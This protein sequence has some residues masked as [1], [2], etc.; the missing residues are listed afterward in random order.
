M[1]GISDRL[2]SGTGINCRDDKNPAHRCYRIN[3]LVIVNNMSL[4]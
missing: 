1:K 3:L 2:V 4:V